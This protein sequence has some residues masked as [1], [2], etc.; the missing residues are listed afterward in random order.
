MADKHEENLM[1]HRYDGIQEYD[2]PC[3]AWWHLIFLGTFVFSVFYYIFF[4]LG[5]V[6][7][8]VVDAHDA[9]VARDLQSR[10]S[11][12]GELAA[13]APTLHQ[14][15]NEPDWMTVGASV[16]TTHCKSCHADGGAGSVGPNLTDDHFKNVKQLVDVAR[17]VQDG[18]AQGSMPAWR[19][20]LHP[21]EIVLVSAY[22]ASLRGRNLPGPRGA[23]G[24][25]I[26]PW[27]AEVESEPGEP[28]PG[29]GETSSSEPELPSAVE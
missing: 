2:N 7:W 4:Q 10:F 16:Y 11:E 15:M 14:Y 19:N 21:N 26:P 3:P 9:A 25:V 1:D 28:E 13:D 27:S 22:V 17:V 12:I 20:R 18:A 6:G 23:E 5:A 8:T 24:N 29:E